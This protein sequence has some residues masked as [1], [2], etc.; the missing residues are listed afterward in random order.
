MKHCFYFMLTIGALLFTGCAAPQTPEAVRDFAK[1]NPLVMT[2]ETLEVDR[3]LSEV[4][5]GFNQNAP[6]CLDVS[7]KSV[8]WT[9]EHYQTEVVTYNAEVVNNPKKT[10]LHVQ[11]NGTYVMVIDAVPVADR[12]TEVTLYRSAWGYDNIVSAVKG[13]ATGKKGC[14]TFQ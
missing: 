9:G 2:V 13:W 10:E 8:F 4:A 11:R 3:P 14:P 6:K 5:G 7:Y 1:T 12:K